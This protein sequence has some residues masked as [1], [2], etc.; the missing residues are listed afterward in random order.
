MSAQEPSPTAPLPDD[1]HDVIGLEMSPLFG[2]FAGL[3][4]GVGPQAGP[5]TTGPSGPAKGEGT[6]KLAR[7]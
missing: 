6:V 3:S 7:S 2:L 5:T 1:E 4:A